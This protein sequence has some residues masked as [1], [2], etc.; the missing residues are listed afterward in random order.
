MRRDWREQDE[1]PHMRMGDHEPSAL[2]ITVWEWIV[3]VACALG[4]IA[5]V[6]LAFWALAYLAGAGVLR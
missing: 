3:V 6:V 2:D 1:L 4:V 5:A